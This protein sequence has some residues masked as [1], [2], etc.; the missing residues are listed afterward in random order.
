MAD[1]LATRI[2]E[3]RNDAKLSREQVAAA[4]DVSLSTVVR[5]ETGRTQRISLET[6]V[7]IARV[8]EKP[9]SYFMEELVA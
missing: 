3:A 4:L 2:R 5:I 8:T 7:T 9:L 6:L 1:E